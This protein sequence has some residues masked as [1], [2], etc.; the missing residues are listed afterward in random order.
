MSIPKI[1]HYCWLSG[2]DYPEVVEKCIA[3]WK[4]KLYDCEFVLWDLNR[5]QEIKSDWVKSAIGVKKWA[6]AADYV[7]LYALYNYGGIYLDTDVLVKKSFDSL[8]DRAYFIGREKRNFVLE[9][10]VIGAEPRQRWIGKCLDF[11]RGRTFSLKDINKKEILLPYVMKACLE[12][13][14]FDLVESIEMPESESGKF[15]Y[16]PYEYF[17]PCDNQN[18]YIERSEKSFCVHLFNGAWESEYQKKYT[19]ILNFYSD[20]YS[21]LVGK[22]IASFFAAKEKIF[23]N[24]SKE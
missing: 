14:G 7:R 9:A 10:A 12:K 5:I 22:I 11:Y 13:N 6:F 17:S 19:E 8:L 15:F 23:Q 3:S 16:F 18:G 20:K 2:S 24:F 1:I 21:S 4:K